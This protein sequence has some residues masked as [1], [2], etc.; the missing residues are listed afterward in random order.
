MQIGFGETMKNDS[1]DYLFYFPGVICGN[2]YTVSLIFPSSNS[3]RNVGASELR[4]IV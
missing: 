1:N 2:R 4:G 3:C